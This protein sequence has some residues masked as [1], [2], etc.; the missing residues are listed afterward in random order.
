M[1]REEGGGYKPILVMR[2]RMVRQTGRGGGEERGGEGGS[3]I[4][5]TLLW[6]GVIVYSVRCNRR[7][8]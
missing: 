2:H 3:N 8:A 7:V 1:V 5:L 6:G 4:M